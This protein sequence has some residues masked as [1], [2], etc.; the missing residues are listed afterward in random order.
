[1][2]IISISKFL[3]KR[4][5]QTIRLAFTGIIVF[6][7]CVLLI[8]FY[9]FSSQAKK[10][11]DLNNLPKADAIVVLTGEEVR[12][13]SAVKLLKS[14][15]GKRLLI[16]GVSKK[17]TDRTVIET[18]AAQSVERYCCIDL[19]RLSLDT[20]GNAK[21][22]AEWVYLHNFE[23]VIV[24]TSSYHMLRSLELLRQEMPS[25]QLIPAQ[26]IPSDLK[27]KSTL[28]MMAS[29]KVI[30]EYGKLLVTKARLEPLAKYVWTSLDLRT[31]S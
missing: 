18:Y 7:L 30:I 21:H 15:Y 1:M 26:V 11:A 12:I 31:N 10:Q 14:Q 9:N 25:V 5:R 24:V 3:S 20:M 29:P 2:K 8:G 6:C 28:A 23:E 22:T 17:V 4:L 27:G 19:D 16:S 13:R